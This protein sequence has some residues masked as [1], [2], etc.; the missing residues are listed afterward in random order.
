MPGLEERLHALE[1]SHRMWKP[2]DDGWQPGPQPAEAHSS[3]VLAP[4]RGVLRMRSWLDLW[5]ETPG[6]FLGHHPLSHSVSTL[7]TRPHSRAYRGRGGQ[8]GKEWSWGNTKCSRAGQNTLNARH[9]AMKGWS[10]LRIMLRKDT[11][12]KML[13]QQKG[14]EKK[15]QS[16]PTV[17]KLN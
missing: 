2:E 5:R 9:S 6:V 17:G 1:D 4:T 13:L 3:G 16:P 8:E 12:T 14:W 15:V 10:A 11:P 7:W